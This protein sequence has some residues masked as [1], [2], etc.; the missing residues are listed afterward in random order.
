MECLRRVYVDGGEKLKG[1]S[2]DGFKLAPWRKA[3][4]R[5]EAEEG[6]NCAQSDSFES[7]TYSA[8]QSVEHAEETGNQVGDDGEESRDAVDP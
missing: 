5:L 6:A 2:A 1:F 8:E 7:G 4:A 3:P